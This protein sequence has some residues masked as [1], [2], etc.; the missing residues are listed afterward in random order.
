MNKTT[1]KSDFTGC[2]VIDPL[3]RIEGHLRMEVHVENGFISEA[4]SCGTLFRGIEN[5]LIGRDPQDAQHFTQRTC[6]VC[7]YTHALCT[8]RALED[9]IGIEI[10]K[11]ATLIRNMVLGIQYMHDHLVHF[12]HLH[13]LDFI[14]IASVTDA[15]VQKTAKLA[16]SISDKPFLEAD[17]Q[18]TKNKIKGLIDSQQLGPFAGAY[19]TGGHPAYYLDAESNLLLV[20]HYLKALRLQVKTARAMAVF[21]AKNPH[22]Q[23]IIAG[24]I[25]CYESL[26]PEN[27]ELFYSLYEETFMFI[28]TILIPDMILLGNEYKDWTNYGEGINFLTFGEFPMPG[29]ERDLESRWLK[30]GYILNKDLSKV[31]PFEPEKIAEHIRHSWYK[32]EEVL[33]PYD[34]VTEPA[35][36]KMGDLDRYSWMKAPRYDDKVM[37]TGPLAQMLISYARGHPEVTEN[38]DFMLDKLNIK[39]EALFSTIGRTVARAVECLTISQQVHVWYHELVANLASGDIQIC[40]DVEIPQNAQGVGYLT[41]PRGGLSHWMRIE[42]GLISNFQ[43]VVPSTWNF[44]P[45]DNKG[46]PGPVESSLIGTPVADPKRPVEILRSVHAFDPCIACSVHV[47]DNATNESR[48]FKIL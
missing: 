35:Y 47:I 2:I 40:E 37:E 4:R 14:D 36:T 41:A 6:G 22:T 16:A 1:P 19:S 20:T 8:T 23:F 42:D 45:R 12:Y 34:G 11:N 15:D 26:K 39:I 7:T 17:F 29:K 27:L 32:G 13:G 10:P 48:E 44:G 18:E 43:L 5:I 25:T 3:T 33:S 24:G 46:R 28:H 9:A 38:M 31:Y 30:P 21:G